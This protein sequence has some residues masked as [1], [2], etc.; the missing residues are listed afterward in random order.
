MKNYKNELSI[1]KKIKRKKNGSE[2]IDG[3]AVEKDC[4]YY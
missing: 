1:N 4:Y 3:T 2:R